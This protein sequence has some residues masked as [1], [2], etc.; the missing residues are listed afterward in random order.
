MATSEPAAARAAG[1]GKTRMDELRAIPG[2]WD[3]STISR[4]FGV[5][6]QTVWIWVHGGR[7]TRD[8]KI[9]HHY[10]VTLDTVRR[11][12]KESDGQT[13]RDKAAHVDLDGVGVNHQMLPEATAKL[14][15]SDGWEPDTILKWGL[16]SWDDT[17]RTRL[18]ATGQARQLPPTGRPRGTLETKPRAHNDNRDKVRKAVV[19]TYRKLVSQEFTDTAARGAVAERLGL[20][21]KQVSRHLAAARQ[22]PDEYGDIPQG[23]S[24]RGP[25]RAPGSVPTAVTPRTS[26]KGKGKAIE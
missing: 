17:G 5:G 14:G 12:R 7:R 24:K 1:K 10:D 6:V 20:N 8:E 21:R 26:Q 13:W 4:V 2:P 18:D 11:W 9:A 23:S 3:C 16:T 22:L 15:G 25:R 19:T